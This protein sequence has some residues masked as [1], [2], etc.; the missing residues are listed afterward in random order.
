VNPQK[1]PIGDSMPDVIVK[2]TGKK[3]KGV[4]ALRNFKKDEVI[5]R[6]DCS[7]VFYERDIDNISRHHLNHAY[8]LGHGK[9]FFMKSPE[10]FINHSCNPNAFDKQGVAFAMKNIKKGE[11]IIYDYS[12][13]GEEIWRMKC[14]C[15]SKN[16]RKVI[17]GQFNKLDKKTQKKYLPYLEE[18]YKKK[19]RK[20]LEKL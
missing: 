5:L 6:M 9:N 13:S 1:I 17:Y 14:H 8:H 20:E 16:C 19:H 4:F 10:K 7:D 3:G 2:N 11:E 12:I 15:K 18:W